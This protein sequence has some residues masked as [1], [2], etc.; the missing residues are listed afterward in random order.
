MQLNKVTCYYLPLND[1]YLT[2][3]YFVLPV[4]CLKLS[5]SHFKPATF[6]VR[7]YLK[8]I[9]IQLRSFHLL[10]LNI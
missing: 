9:L 6:L 4:I 2:F 5:C 8:F 3:L 1:R 7:I 10:H